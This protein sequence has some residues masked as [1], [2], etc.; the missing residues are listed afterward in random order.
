MGMAIPGVDDVSAVNP[1]ITGANGATGTLVGYNPKKYS[2]KFLTKF[3]QT[4]NLAKISNTDY[5][6]DIKDYGDTVIIRT[7]PDIQ[8]HDYVKGQDLS[9]D[10]Y[11]TDIVTLTIDHGKYWAFTT[12]DIDL[13][14]TDLK[15]FVEAWTTD[16]AK[17]VD[18]AIEREVLDF[19]KDKAGEYNFGNTAGKVSQSYKLGALTAGRAINNKTFVEVL[20]DCDSV[21]AEQD[22]PVTTEQDKFWMILPQ[23][24]INAAGVSDLRLAYAMGNGK[25]FLLNG[26]Q[27]NIPKVDIFNI[28]RSNL[29][30]VAAGKQD[31][32]TTAAQVT[33]IPFGHTSALTFAAQ[34]TQN[35]TIRNPRNFGLLHRGLIVYGYKVIL[36]KCLGMLIAYRSANA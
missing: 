22:L 30:P 11:D 18:I 21:M 8:V 10:V 34:L 26:G 33:Y 24:A 17:R 35:E 7:V 5:Q 27:N 9:Y 20:A 6:G 12:D 25:S 2:G 36:A 16:A 28:Y 14:Q 23:W 15:K 4:C 29:L 1:V 31:D 3:Y 32:G 19:L 13:K